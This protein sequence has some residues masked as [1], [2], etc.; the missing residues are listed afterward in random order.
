MRRNEC[1]VQID[2]QV[3]HQTSQLRYLG[4][5]IYEDSELRKISRIRSKLY[6]KSYMI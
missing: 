1:V 2:G 4:S 5:T 6:S 3:I